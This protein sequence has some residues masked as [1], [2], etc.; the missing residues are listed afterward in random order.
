MDDWFQDVKS[1]FEY[2]ISYG[3][4]RGIIEC[5]D[6]LVLVSGYRKKAGFT[7][8]IRIVFASFDQSRIVENLSNYY[9]E[10]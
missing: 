8:C 3:K 1:R 6:L 2:G 5:G 4:N 7:N 10:P 9:E